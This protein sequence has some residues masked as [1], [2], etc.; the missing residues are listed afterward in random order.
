MVLLDLGLRIAHRQQAAV[1][2]ALSCNVLLLIIE[3]EPSRSF[4]MLT[5]WTRA[6]W[7]LAHSNWY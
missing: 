3:Y 5:E 6:G 1:N 7:D 4:L 2:D